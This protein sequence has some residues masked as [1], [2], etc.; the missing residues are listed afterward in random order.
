MAKK[1]LKENRGLNIDL[2]MIASRA[3]MVALALVSS[4][5]SP[6]FLAVASADLLNF[7]QPSNPTVKSFR[8]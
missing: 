1:N 4:I 6:A 7:S 3:E 2:P 8:Y 5:L